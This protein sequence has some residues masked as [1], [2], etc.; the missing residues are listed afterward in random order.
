MIEKAAEL[1]LT[2]LQKFIIDDVFINGDFN[3][4]PYLL[5]GLAFIAVFYNILHLYAAKV[6]IKGQQKLHT[7]MLNTIMRKLHHSNV[8]TFHQYGT[9]K[10]VQNLT[11][12]VNQI[13][14]SFASAFPMGIMDLFGALVISII[15]GFNNLPILI[16]I[17]VI[18]TF[19]IVLGKYYGPKLKMEQRESANMKSDLIVFMEEGISSSREVIAFNRESY[20]KKEYNQ[21]FQNYFK[22][23]MKENRLL[24]KQMLSAEPLK[25]AVNLLVLGYGGYCVMQNTLSI[26]TF[27]VIYQFSSQLLV[28]Y[29]RVFNFL[30][31]M[32]RSFAFVDRFRDVMNIEDE[33]DGMQKLDGSISTIEMNK[34][35]FKYDANERTILNKLNI[36]IPIGKKVAFVGESGSGKSTVS[37]LLTRFYEPTDGEIMI[38][39]QPLSNISRDSWQKKVSIVF[40]EPYLFPDTII[41]NLLMGR[42]IP[43]DKVID[44]CKKMQIHD[45][46]LTLPKGYNTNVGERG[47]K[48]SGGQKQRLAL[49]RALLADSEILI[50]DEATSALD[51]KTEHLVQKNID[52]LRKGKTTIIIAHRL[53]TIRNAD[54]I[55]VIDKGKIA[56]SGTHSELLKTNGKYRELSIS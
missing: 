54:I 32:S 39:Q 20:E 27:V 56:E 51:M 6:R 23:I 33:K 37:Q 9:G 28:S 15:I 12:D 16:G 3:L 25:W 55:F 1:S 4:L 38:N 45:F 40:Q 36:D 29:Q 50:L 5:I 26:G 30:I 22:Q 41:N 47:I 10:Y 43:K 46:I 42:A 13:S 35:Q 2:G 52:T 44:L 7:I 49:V 21:A 48:L 17:M 18:S 34:I 11:N 19:Y 24:N 31:N 14:S 8:H 53:S